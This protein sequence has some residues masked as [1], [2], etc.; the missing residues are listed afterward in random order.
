MFASLLTA[1][2]VLVGLPPGL[3]N[4]NQDI[5][6]FFYV[7]NVSGVDVNVKVLADGR[8]VFWHQLP[9]KVVRRTEATEVP[10]PGDHPAVE[11]KIRL[12]RNTRR[13]EVQELNSNRKAKFNVRNFTGAT[14]VFALRSSTIRSNSNRTTIRSTNLDLRPGP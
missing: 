10:P 7:V 11:V 2:A 1:I 14:V 12:N 5:L 4:Q 13:L 8:E 9:A 3:A 6:V